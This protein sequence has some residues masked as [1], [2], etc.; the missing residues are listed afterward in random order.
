MTSSIYQKIFNYLRMRSWL[1]K[2]KGKTT[3]IIYIISSIFSIL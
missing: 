3:G 1:C 2:R